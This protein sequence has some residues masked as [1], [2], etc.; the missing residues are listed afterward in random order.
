[1]VGQAAIDNGWDLAPVWSICL[2]T[3]IVSTCWPV[4]RRQPVRIRSQLGGGRY[5]LASV[6]REIAEG[7][8]RVAEIVR[9]LKTFTYLD[10]APIQ[11]VDIH[12]D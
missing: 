12:E 9:A 1:M 3:Q 2:L 8:G 4:L 10:Q 11:N 7:S 5:T 6:L